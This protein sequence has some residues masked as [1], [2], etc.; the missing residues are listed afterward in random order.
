MFNVFAA[1]WA[2]T[3]GGPVNS[4]HTLGTYIYWQSIRMFRVGYG[5]AVAL[6]MMLILLIVSLLYWRLRRVE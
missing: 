3:K 1:I 5:T 6:V 4:T 2:M